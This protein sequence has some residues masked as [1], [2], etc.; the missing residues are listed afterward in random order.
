MMKSL[1][2]TSSSM[3]CGPDRRKTWLLIESYSIKERGKSIFTSDS[4]TL[5][6]LPRDSGKMGFRAL[7]ERWK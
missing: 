3:V 5:S 7:R 1:T 2:V 4:P 6:Y